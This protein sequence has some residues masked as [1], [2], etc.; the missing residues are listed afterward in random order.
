MVGEQQA[1]VALGIET[2]MANRSGDRAHVRRIGVVVL[3]DL[4]G[5]AEAR[6]PDGRGDLIPHRTGGRVRA[7]RIQG[8]HHDAIASAFAERADRLPHPRLAEAHSDGNV[9]TARRELLAHVPR[10]RIVRHR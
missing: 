3:D 4:D 2:R 1:V 8:Q 9:E 6:E 10:E 5:V 7:L